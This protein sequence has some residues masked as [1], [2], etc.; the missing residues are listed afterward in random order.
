MKNFT[1]S[2]D[3]I[4]FAII[5]DLLSAKPKGK[6]GKCPHGPPVVEKYHRWCDRYSKYRDQYTDMREQNGER[7]DFAGWG[8]TLEQLHNLGFD[9]SRDAVNWHSERLRESKGKV[10]SWKAISRR[11]NRLDERVWK[12]LRAARSNGLL[13]GI[14]EVSVRW[15]TYGYIPAKCKA[16]AEQ[17]AHALL[18]VPLALDTSRLR[19]NWTDFATPEKLGPLQAG[20]SDMS[21]FDRQI[22]KLKERAANEIAQLEERRE[23]V[24]L[25]LAMTMGLLDID[26][27]EG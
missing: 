11:E 21:T 13:P 23:K 1:P 15:D 17:L 4:R 12:K 19:I 14:F 16:E 27:D 24:S 26:E 9:G 10:S 7:G 22:R 2:S 3:A 20:I 6:L 25:A 18:V 5:D 8:Y